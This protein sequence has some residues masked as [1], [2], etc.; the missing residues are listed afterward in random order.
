MLQIEPFWEVTVCRSGHVNVRQTLNRLADPQAPQGEPPFPAP[1][2]RSD[3]SSHS[4]S[5]KGFIS[6]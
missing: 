2:L 6:P 5:R 3:G 4:L 1:A